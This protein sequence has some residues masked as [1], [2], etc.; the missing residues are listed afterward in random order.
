M[1]TGSRMRTAAGAIHQVG[2]VVVWLSAQ[3]AAR[4]IATPTATRQLS[5]MTKSYQNAANAR[6]RLVIAVPLPRRL[7]QARLWSCQR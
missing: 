6:N 4:A 3:V 1:L 5:P 2:A 7:R